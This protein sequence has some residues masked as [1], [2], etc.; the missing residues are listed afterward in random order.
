MKIWCLYFFALKSC[1][2]IEE[3]INKIRGGQDNEKREND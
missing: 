3:K 1:M 2:Y